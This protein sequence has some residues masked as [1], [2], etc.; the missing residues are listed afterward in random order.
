M[1]LLIS[2]LFHLTSID[3][4][5]ENDQPD[6]LTVDKTE[7][8]AKSKQKTNFK[9]AFRLVVAEPDDDRYFSP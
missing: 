2:P 1:R 3:E 4:Q 7:D 8:E 5:H 9:S 6:A